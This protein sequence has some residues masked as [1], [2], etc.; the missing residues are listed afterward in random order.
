MTKSGGADFVLASRVPQKR[1]APEEISY[2]RHDFQRSPSLIN[3]TKRRGSAYH[4]AHNIKQSL[5][6]NDNRE[7]YSSKKYIIN[8]KFKAIIKK[9]CFINLQVLAF[10]RKSSKTIKNVRKRLM[11][12]GLTTF[13]SAW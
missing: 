13:G 11:M 4:G 8:S 9:Y 5:R 7:G 12:F 3:I 1:I 10:Y 6:K 2:K